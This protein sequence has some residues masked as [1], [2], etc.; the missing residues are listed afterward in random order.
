MQLTVVKV[1][2]VVDGATLSAVKD[3]DGRIHYNW[4]GTVTDSVRRKTQRR[5]AVI[6]RRFDIKE[7]SG[8]RQLSLPQEGP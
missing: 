8:A 3:R 2:A 6:L 5:M 7:A 1:Q 4:S